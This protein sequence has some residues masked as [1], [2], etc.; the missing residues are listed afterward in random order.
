MQKSGANLWP[1]GS[2]EVNFTIFNSDLIIGNGRDKPIIVSGDP[3]NARYMEVEFLVDLATSTNVN[4]PVGKFVIAHSQYTVISGVPS[5]PS[6]IYVSAK[7]TSGTY[8]G[9]PAP[10]DAIQLDL[11]RRVSLGS[12][13]ITGL[14][15]YRDKLLVTFERGV[16]PINLGV[17]R[18]DER[19]GDPEK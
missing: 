19:H 8:F 9:D 16:L 14:V 2:V 17:F 1:A 3:V 4:T 7:G 12:A 15:A 11:G 6:S 10:N 5:E 18:W 13:T